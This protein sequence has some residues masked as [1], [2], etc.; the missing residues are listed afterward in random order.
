MANEAGDETFFGPEAIK[1]SVLLICQ[2]ENSDL[3]WMKVVKAS[4]ESG[5]P[6]NRV[7]VLTYECQSCKRTVAVHFVVEAPKPE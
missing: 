4:G 7:M 5:L 3:G 6:T 2:C 1:T